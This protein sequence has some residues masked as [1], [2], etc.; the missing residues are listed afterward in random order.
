[1]LGEL[2]GVDLLLLLTALDGPDQG[3]GPLRSV[4]AGRGDGRRPVWVGRKGPAPDDRVDQLGLARLE[5]PDD[6]HAGPVVGHRAAHD[7]E[8]LLQIGPVVGRHGLAGETDEIGQLPRHGVGAGAH[9]RAL[10]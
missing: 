7:G 6:E 2:G 5:L 3:H 10:P 8:P 9:T 1:M 4:D